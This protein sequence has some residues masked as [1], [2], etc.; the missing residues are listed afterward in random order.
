MNVMK[1]IGKSFGVLIAIASMIFT[2]DLSAQ[3][4]DDSQNRNNNAPP[5]AESSYKSALGLRGGFESGIT[6]K[7]FISGD[8]ALEFILSAPY[9]YRGYRITGLYEIQKPILH[10]PYSPEGLFF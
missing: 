9:H 10:F 4:R 8:R 2:N 5:Q 6:F 1:T 7:H 3:K